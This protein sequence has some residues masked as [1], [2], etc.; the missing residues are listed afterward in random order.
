M[1]LKIAT[2]RITLKGW[3]PPIWRLVE[4]PLATN[5]RSLHFLIQDA[6]PW[7]CYHLY[8]FSIDDA[9]YGDPHTDYESPMLDA[10]T[11]DLANLVR[12]GVGGFL[13]IY[14]FGD[15]WVHQID[16]EQI[17]D[18]KYGAKYPRL[19]GGE[20]KAPPED[21]GGLG[22]FERFLEAMSDPKHP[23]H[24]NMLDWHGMKFDPEAFDMKRL[25]EAVRC[26]MTEELAGLDDN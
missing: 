21:V 11:I 5:L 24:E 13:Y 12:R 19:I 2:L 8:E 23:E 20:R 10:G 7:L 6:M 22:G 4:V 17:F 25:R 16:I 15:Y 9:R 1:P 18:A 3:K 14:D 26:S